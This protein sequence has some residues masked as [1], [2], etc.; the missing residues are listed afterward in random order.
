MCYTK[1]IVTKADDKVIGFHI[2][3]PS[4]GEVTQ[5][6]AIAMKCGVTKSI[7]DMT[8]GIHPTIAEEVVS[9]SK[10]KADDPNAEKSGC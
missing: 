3:S 7:V 1:L 9:L 6:I 8:V 2:L 10:T 4:A 5:G